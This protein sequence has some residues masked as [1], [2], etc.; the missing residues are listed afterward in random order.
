MAQRKNSALLTD[1]ALPL[2]VER[3]QAERHLYRFLREGWHVL[4]PETEF[5][6]GW[7]IELVA[8]Y[9]EL[10]TQGQIRRLIVNEAPKH[11]KS[12]LCTIFWPV[13]IWLKK[14]SLRFMFTSYSSTLSTQHSIKRRQ[15]IESEWFQERWGDRFKLSSDQNVKTHF[16]NTARGAM[17]A[18]S[19]ASGG[20]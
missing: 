10:V 9:L 2:A 18:A 6:A 20:T 11:T 4:E 16:E 5:V 14:P 13:W 17:F 15:L 7:H 3:E 19:L 8:E 12:A 1:P